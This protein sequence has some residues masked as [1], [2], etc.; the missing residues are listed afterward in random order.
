MICAPEFPPRAAGDPLLDN[1]GQLG[2][3]LAD[4]T[5]DSRAVKHGSVFVAYPGTVQ[6]GRR[7]IADAIARGAAA[8]LWEREGFHWDERWNV[9][10][11]GITGLRPRISDIA[12]HVYGDPSRSYVAPENAPRRWPNSSLSASS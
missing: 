9:P 8:V 10:N 12:G 11:L 2:V 4:L 3:P 7:F 5:A 1:L 6:D